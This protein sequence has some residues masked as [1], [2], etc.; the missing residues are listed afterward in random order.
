A[1]LGGWSPWDSSLYQLDR[2]RPEAATKI[3]G[4]EKSFDFTMFHK[5]IWE[6]ARKRSEGMLADQKGG[7][8]CYRESLPR[9][10]CKVAACAQ[11]KIR[12]VQVNT[13]DKIMRCYQ[14]MAAGGGT[15]CHGF[16]LGAS[17]GRFMTLAKE[18]SD[19]VDSKDGG[20]LG[21]ITRGKVEPRL[22]VVAFATP[23][24]GCSPPFRVKPACF[25][26]VFVEDRR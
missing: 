8:L 12:R 13:E 15:D 7:A 26:L 1:A 19:A 21:W 14:A 23:R 25:Q 3:V 9:P 6:R 4:G 5:D 11:V 24:G 2:P 10:E 17:L 16:L 20:D 18:K 22:D